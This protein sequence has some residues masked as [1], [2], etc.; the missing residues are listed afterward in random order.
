MGRLRASGH[1]RVFMECGHPTRRHRTLEEKGESE[2]EILGREFIVYD[3][4]YA[5][6][7]RRV[8]AAAA[9]TFAKMAES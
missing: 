6:F 9:D 4:L 8:R 3:A 5:A 2:H 1:L 7:T